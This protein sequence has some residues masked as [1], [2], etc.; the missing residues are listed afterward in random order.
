MNNPDLDVLIALSLR[1]DIG[2]GDHTSLA[3]VPSGQMGKAKL[4]VKE[5]GV[6][7]GVPVAAQVFLCSKKTKKPR[8]P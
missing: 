6:L 5:T 4:L 8:L 2:D 1:E 3:C 7:C